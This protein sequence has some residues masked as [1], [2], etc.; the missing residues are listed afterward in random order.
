MVMESCDLASVL[1][2]AAAVS[3]VAEVRWRGPK[4]GCCVSLGLSVGSEARGK[5]GMW[6]TRKVF[7]A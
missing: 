1:N 4:I 3:A 2:E 7:V 6:G 5:L